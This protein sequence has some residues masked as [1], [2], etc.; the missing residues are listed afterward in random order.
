MKP[1]KVKAA[2][3]YFVDAKQPVF[4]WG[5][6][7]VGK[8][9]LVRQVAAERGIGLIDKR[10]SQSDPTELKGY[11]FPDQKKKVMTFFTDEELPTSGEGIL[12]LDEL[13]TAP[14][15]VQAPGYQLVLDRRLGKYQLPPGWVVVGAGNRAGDRS[16]AHAMSAA[17]ANRFQHI[18]VDPNA[19]EWYDWATRQKISDYTRGFIRFRPA[20]VHSFD[21]ATNPRAFPTGRSWAKADEVIKSD[22]PDDLKLDLI[23]G[24]V[25]EGAAVEYFAYIRTHMDLPTVDE[26]L[27]NPDNAPIP[28]SPAGKYAI[29]TALE[30]AI[31]KNSLP[32]LMTYITR[33]TTEFQALFMIQA[34]KNREVVRT[35]EFID[36]VTK[37]Q[38]VVL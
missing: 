37:N 33:M 2:L 25:G 35:A 21:P 17:L 1:S 15:Q 11:P 23:K 27:M 18:D 32:R 5:P 13:N 9:D 3:N 38:H 36:W 30:S 26:I 34:A 10:L 7:G 12:F 28:D 31:S 22:L 6:P 8:S 29:C 24:T 14:Q 16:I 4:L 19:D 20:L